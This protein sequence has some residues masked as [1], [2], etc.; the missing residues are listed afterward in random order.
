MKSL[1]SKLIEFTFNENKNVCTTL[2]KQ[3]NEN[4]YNYFLTQNL[5]NPN[6]I[7]NI[8]RNI[9]LSII[10]RASKSYLEIYGVQNEQFLYL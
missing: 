5:S 3:D 4:S 6:V 8:I 1:D 2:L 9:F 7:S 10:H